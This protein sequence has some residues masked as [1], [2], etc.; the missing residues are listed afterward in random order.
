MTCR[1]AMTPNPVSCTTKDSVI[2]SA[3]LMKDK[4]VGPVP[5]VDDRDS[6]KLVGIITDRDI[7]VKV[8]AAGRDAQ[9]TAIGDVMSRDLVTCRPEDDL[10]EAIAAMAARQVRRIPIVDEE[11]HLLGIIAQADVALCESPEMTGM[12]VENISEPNQMV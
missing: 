4:D 3:R 1:D 12:V 10:K 5:V 9:R 7:A 6:Q 8:V 2:D 11:R